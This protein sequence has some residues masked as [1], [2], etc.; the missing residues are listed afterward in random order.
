M[1]L[2]GADVTFAPA[3]LE[4]SEGDRLLAHLLASLPWEVHRIRMFGRVVDSP[5]L[6]AW[7]GDEGA[8]YRYSGTRFVPHPWIPELLALRDRVAAACGVPFN[9][10]LA[11]LYRDGADRMGWHSDDEPELGAQPV[12][13]SVSLGAERTFRFR[14]KAGGE[15]TAIA[16]THG[17]LLTMAGDTQ[18]LY[19][20]ELPPRKRVSDPR[21]NLTFRHIA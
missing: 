21:I 16:L 17:S 6:S 15:P 1:D 19:K 18:R 11:N 10:V 14:A 20:H 8:V 5:R 12:I 4:A 7:M 13:A 9:S 2:A 3:W